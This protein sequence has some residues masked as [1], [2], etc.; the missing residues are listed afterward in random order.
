[1]SLKALDQLKIFIN[2][3]ILSSSWDCNGDSFSHRE[4]K[5]FLSDPEL[6]RIVRKYKNKQDITKR[7]GI[8]RYKLESE[9]RE[10]VKLLENFRISDITC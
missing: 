4:I 5:I 3:G 1:M 2:S 9:E 10:L 8:L 6:I 7:L